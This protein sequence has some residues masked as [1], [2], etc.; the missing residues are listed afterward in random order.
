MAYIGDYI[1]ESINEGEFLRNVAYISGCKHNCSKCFSPQTW[2]F[3]Y[4]IEFDDRVQNIIINDMKENTL[5]KGITLCGGDSF[6]SAKDMVVFLEKFKKELPN[7]TVWAFTGFTYEEIMDSKDVHMIQYLKMCDVI[8]D[9]QFVESEKDL[10][11]KFRGSKSQ[12]VI[13]V[14][15]SL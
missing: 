1:K 6:Y 8:I 14:Q 3:K 10:T 13:D 7:H 5:V 15:K 11:L 4:G 9:G 12:R 2:D